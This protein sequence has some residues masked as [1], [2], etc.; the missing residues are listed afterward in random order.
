MKP[1]MYKLTISK[2]DMEQKA[3]HGDVILVAQHYKASGKVK[4]EI[5]CMSSICEGSVIHHEEVG[6][7]LQYVRHD[8]KLEIMLGESSEI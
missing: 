8:F 4:V 1:Q 3:D 7:H 6:A 2:T 5:R